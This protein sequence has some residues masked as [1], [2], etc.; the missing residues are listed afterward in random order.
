M[1]GFDPAHM[2]LDIIRAYHFG[3]KYDTTR[4]VPITVPFTHVLLTEL[5]VR[6]LVELEVIH[7][8]EWTVRHVFG[9]LDGYYALT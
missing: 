5:V 4:K 9:Y 8:R 6:Y 1:N 3:S 2:R 7:P